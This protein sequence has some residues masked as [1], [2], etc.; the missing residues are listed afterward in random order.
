MDIASITPSV[1]ISFGGNAL[2]QEGDQSIERSFAGII[3][4][5]R[6]GHRIFISHGNGPQVG[7]IFHQQQLTQDQYPELK[8]L[9]VCVADTQGRIGY[10]LQQTLMN[11]LKKERLPHDVVTCLTQ[12]VVDPQDRS[13][14]N[15]TKF[16]GPAFHLSEVQTL[17]ERFQWDMRLDPAKGWRR[18]VPSPAPVRIVEGHF[19]K[20]C[21]EWGVITICAGGGGIPV[22]E[23]KHGMLIG[24]EAVID[25]DQTSAFLAN[26][27]R[28]PTWI[29]LTDVPNV[30]VDFQ[31]KQQKPL[32]KMTVNQM[33]KHFKDGQFPEG[34]MGPKV[35]SAIAFIKRGGKR[36]IIAHLHDLSAALE[37]FKGT[38]VIPD[39]S[40]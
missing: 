6:S 15:P 34:S 8:S 14:Q 22:I 10:L 38:E 2:A 7:R 3:G 37:G 17:R 23:S 1:F 32:R 4:L 28:I 21:S 13:F 31:G 26:K 12:V 20:Q 11:L 18:V 30:F 25:K 16:I 24:V 19:L 5:L 39:N 9:D 27:L 36:A 29:S 40:E 35:A 33:E